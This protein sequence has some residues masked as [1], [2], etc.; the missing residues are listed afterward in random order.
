MHKGS[1]DK[2]N[3][4]SLKINKAITKFNSSKL[5]SLSLKTDS[6]AV[7]SEVRRITK[8][9][10][11]KTRETPILSNITSDA[12]NSYFASISTDPAYSAPPLKT[13]ASPLPSTGPFTEETVFRYLDKLRPTSTG[14]D[15]IPA[16]FLRLG[17]SIFS[18]PIAH[19]FAISAHNSELPK[20]WKTAI[21]HPIPKIPVPLSNN[22]MRPISVLPILSRIQ[23]R[24]IVS[25][26]LAPSLQIL[27]PPL[28]ISNQFAYRATGSTTAAVINILSHVSHLLQTETQVHVLTFDYSKAF[29][30]LSHSSLATK[31]AKC[32]IPDSIH[33]LILNN[34]TE[35]Y[36]CTL[37]NSQLSQPAA[38]TASV[39]QG[40]VFGPQLFNL[41]STDLNTISP[42]NQ[43]IKYAD[44]SYLIVP[45][46]N[47]HTIPAELKHHADWAAASNLKLNP[48]KTSEIVFTRKHT[49]YPP[50]TSN[51]TRVTSLK[52]LGITVDDKLSF[53]PHIQ[54][55]LTTCSQTLFA[56]R[57]LRQTGIDTHSLQTVFHSTTISKLLYCSPA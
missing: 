10:A 42:Q 20:Q 14:A 34:L 29:D 13:T 49:P 4:I 48:S 11:I 39:V 33:N 55:T 32:D 23:E 41:N 1:L 5:S 37:H 45:G 36:H 21:I 27:P 56:F 19:L 7:W 35:R 52:I 43:Y 44:D 18:L 25:H 8:P 50:P 9:T 16:W 24:I 40:S 17:A 12:L 53:T 3:A 28:S 22:D 30:T 38:I 26:Y 6:H 2:A 47:S 31:L 51:V 54:Q 57:L 46:S 15:S